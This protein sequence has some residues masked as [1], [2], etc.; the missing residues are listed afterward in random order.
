MEKDILRKWTHN[1]AILISDKIDFK[2]NL[3]KRVRKGPMYST[4]RKA[5]QEDTAILSIHQTKSTQVN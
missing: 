2:P 1:V 3:I 4:K 5:H